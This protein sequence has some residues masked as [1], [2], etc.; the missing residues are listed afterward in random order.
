MF[1]LIFLSIIA[2]HSLTLQAQEK[3]GAL[4]LLDTVTY[5][6]GDIPRKGGDVKHDFLYT[7]NGTSPLVVT[8]VS[9]SCTCT[10]I[11]YSKQPLYPTKRDKITIVYDPKKEELGRFN[12]VIHLFSNSADGKHIIT[13]Q[14]NVVD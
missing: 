11:I 4:F 6:F 8:R 10:K 5:N 3:K 14:G 1:R 12:K 2:L 7:N 9:T 13:I